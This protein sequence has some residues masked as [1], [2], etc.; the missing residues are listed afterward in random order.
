MGKKKELRNNL[1]SVRR[2]LQ[3]E[4][5]KVDHLEH[6]YRINKKFFQNACEKFGD[7]AVGVAYREARTYVYTNRPRVEVHTFAAGGGGG[8]ATFF[9]PNAVLPIPPNSEV[10][11][12]NPIA[13][14]LK[15]IAD[16]M[17]LKVGNDGS[18][19]EDFVEIVTSEIDGASPEISGKE[20]AERILNALLNERLL[21]RRRA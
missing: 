12:T 21:I 19:M 5:S 16:A 4:K 14:Q 18:V 2:A 17:E 11:I 20:L 10:K 6:D 8:N 15:R 9:G 7:Q 13:E 1:D 3:I